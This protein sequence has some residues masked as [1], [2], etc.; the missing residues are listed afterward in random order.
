MEDH[1]RP[2][3]SA[4]A[5][6]QVSAS[7]VGEF[8]VAAVDVLD[9]LR[10]RGRVAPEEVAWV[11]QLQEQVGESRK[12]LENLGNA[13]RETLEEVQVG[14]IDHAVM[15]R[16]DDLEDVN[17]DIVRT[18]AQQDSEYGIYI[19]ALSEKR[20]GAQEK[21]L[22]E[23]EDVALRSIVYRL[24]QLGQLHYTDSTYGAVYRMYSLEEWPYKH[25][26]AE[27]LGKC[28]K[29]EAEVEFEAKLPQIYQALASNPRA[30]LNQLREQNPFVSG[31]TQ[32][33]WGLLVQREPEIRR[34]AGYHALQS[35]DVEDKSDPNS[36]V[37]PD[38]RQLAP[39]P[40]EEAESDTELDLESKAK[41]AVELIR[42][43][44]GISRWDL[45]ERLDIENQE[46]VKKLFDYMQ[47]PIA[48][49]GEKLISWKE[50]E[51]KESKCYWI[52]PET[53]E[54]KRVSRP[55]KE[56]WCFDQDSGTVLCGQQRAEL[57][58]DQLWVIEKIGK[59]EHSLP[60]VANSTEL[61]QDEA[62][63]VLEELKKRFPGLIHVRHKNR[64]QAVYSINLT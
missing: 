55:E 53:N 45:C 33:A 36:P 39:V 15:R 21:P 50:G 62:R 31:L 22:S 7:R 5:E 20:L 3:L 58:P 10:E 40:G 48:R 44:P 24:V 46:T 56:K 60:R 12:Y 26:S 38:A 6:S 49:Q 41:E 16:W 9:T 32:E 8:C 25:V 27:Q 17:A 34:D 59:G 2:F 29:P 14:Q 63:S 52:V 1:E 47:S 30:T 61:R 54:V 28:M 43:K 4:P 64:G 23:E 37:R 35:I 11:Q 19:S 42:Q 57:R 18:V 13:I 51:D